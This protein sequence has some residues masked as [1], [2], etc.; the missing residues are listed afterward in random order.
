M[1]TLNGIGGKRHCANFAKHLS[2]FDTLD[3]P[4]QLGGFMASILSVAICRPAVPK[5]L[6]KT[7]GMR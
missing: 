1:N 5:T 7:L 2:F 4:R 3:G 6:A